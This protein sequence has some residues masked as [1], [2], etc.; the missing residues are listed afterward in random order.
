MFQLGEPLGC[1]VGK[2]VSLAVPHPC[3]FLLPVLLGTVSLPDPVS[4]WWWL[5]LSLGP[6]L[7]PPSRLFVHRPLLA[8]L[9]ARPRERPGMGETTGGQDGQDPLLWSFSLWGWIWGVCDKLVQQQVGGGN[10]SKDMKDSGD[11][12]HGGQ[13]RPF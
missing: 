12:P 6:L 4:G 1:S 3:A 8:S 2:R 13:R 10:F 7:H 11:C 9:P 5:L